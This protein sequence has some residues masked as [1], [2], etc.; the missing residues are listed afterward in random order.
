MLKYP[1]MDTNHKNLKDI[2]NH[3]H[4][5]ILPSKIWTTMS[6]SLCISRTT[7]AYLPAAGE[8]FPLDLGPVKRSSS[9]AML[10]P[11]ASGVWAI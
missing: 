2:K 9:S 5:C 1:Y 4:A 6:T 3:V 10:E 7:Q 11:D 8:D